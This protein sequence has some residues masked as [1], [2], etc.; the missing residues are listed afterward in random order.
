M[1]KDSAT[2]NQS[3]RPLTNLSVS[4]LS[5]D[6]LRHLSQKLVTARLAREITIK[7]APPPPEN[8]QHNSIRVRNV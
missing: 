5:D 2:L 4:Y 7:G 1:V 6:R 3:I 8:G